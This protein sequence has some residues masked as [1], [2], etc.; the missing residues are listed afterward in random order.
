MRSRTTRCAEAREK[1]L[2]QVPPRDRLQPGATTPPLL[3]PP[4]RHTFAQV[5]VLGPG[6][7]CALDDTEEILSGQLRNE[8]DLAPPSKAAQPQ[9]AGGA[10]TIV[11]DG[12]GGYRVALRGWA[13]ATCGIEG[14]VRR[15]EESHA[16]DWRSRWPQGCK[17]KA[18]GDQIPLGGAGYAAFLKKSECDAYT[19]EISCVTPLHEAAK[20]KGT[21]CEATLKSHLDDT[22]NQQKS[23]C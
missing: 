5:S 1:S 19:T 6:R 22:K 21:A 12:K 14:C 18:D 17:D 15:H 8:D 4:S 20:K 11:C 16:A 13:G 7:T 23:F 10:A 9:A 3:R 2:Q